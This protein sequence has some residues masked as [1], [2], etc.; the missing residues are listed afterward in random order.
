MSVLQ[1]LT[2]RYNRTARFVP[3]ILLM[4][5]LCVL[6][7]TAIPAAVAAWSK[8]A[9]LAAFCLPFV[10]S[11]VVRDRGL[12]AEP[13][14]Y[15]SWGGRPSEVMLRWRSATAKT[16]IARRHQLVRTHLGMDLPDEAAEAADPAEADDAY[17]VATAAL[18]ERTR[19]RTRFPLVF[20][21]NIS[22]GFRRNAYAC[23]FPAI[24]I[25]GLTAAATLAL[26]RWSLVPLGWRQQAALVGFDVLAAVGWWRWLTQDTV[27]RSAEKYAHQLFAS[28]ETLD[29]Q[30][31]QP[32]PEAP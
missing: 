10:V 8:M 2:D 15:Q 32:Q 3:A 17:A 30:S 31:P 19:D 12:R 24:V 20:E 14:L 21:E 23:R 5:P 1:Q 16:A 11:Q 27:R 13:D 28:L 4:L 6:A 7:I 29:T 26:A 25:C 22:Y 18:R 9:V